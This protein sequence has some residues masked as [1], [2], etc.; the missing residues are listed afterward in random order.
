MALSSHRLVDAAITYCVRVYG[1]EST[2]HVKIQ[3]E[4]DDLNCSNGDHTIWAIPRY[5][6]W[7]S[8]ADTFAQFGLKT[9]ISFNIMKMKN[10]VA[11]GLQTE[12][13]QMKDMLESRHYFFLL[14]LIL[15]T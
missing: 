15:N 12:V 2:L 4:L 5:I 1:T 9:N 13:M 6:S 8:S 11:T 7:H 3:L 14:F 10:D